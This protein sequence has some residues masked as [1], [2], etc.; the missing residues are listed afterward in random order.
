MR[1]PRVAYFPDSFHEINGVAHTSRNFVAYA[2]RHNLP[3]TS[4]TSPA[5]A[6]SASSAPISPGS[7]DIPLVASWHTNV[8]EYAARRMR[9]LS[10][11][12]GPLGAPPPPKHAI[13]HTALSV[14]ARFYSLAKVLYAPNPELCAMLERTTHRPCHLMQRGVDTNLF[15]P[16][17]RT[18]PI[19]RPTI[20]LGYVGRLSIEKNVSLL[21]KSTPNSAPGHHP[22]PASSSS[23]TAPKKPSPRASPPPLPRRPPRRSPRHRLRQHGHPRLPLPHRHLRQR[24]PRSPRQRRPRHRHPRRRPQVHRPRLRDRL[25][26][27]R[28]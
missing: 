19:Q 7:S 27:P 20:I 23:A 25:R 17:R 24:R 6:N 28:R 5:P 21:P 15:T 16:T 14:A 12:L 3:P 13:E 18:R 26:R 2:E 22:P 11:H 4:S 1:P 10:R 9:W 8:H